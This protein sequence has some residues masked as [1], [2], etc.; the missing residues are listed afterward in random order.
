MSQTA[1]S[2]LIEENRYMVE[3]RG[4]INIKVNRSNSFNHRLSII[5]FQ[6]KGLTD[7]YW[8]TGFNEKSSKASINPNSTTLKCPF[9]SP[10]LT[11]R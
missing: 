11:F 2:H 5:Y 8:L 4:Q 9:S 10:D 3:H 7:T 6:G 1:Y